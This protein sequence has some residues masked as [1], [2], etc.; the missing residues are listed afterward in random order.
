MAESQNSKQNVQAPE[1]GQTVIVNAIPGQDIVL[2]A[3]F[4]QAEVKMDG[5]NVV[6]EFANGGQVVLDFTDLGEAQAPN[7]V[8][9]DGTVL[10]MQEFLAALGEKEVEPAAGP[11]AG[12]V[13]S[14]GVGQ[15]REG[16][17]EVIDGTDKLDGLDPR[18]FASIVVE[19]LEADVTLENPLPTAGLVAG[20]V[21]E[22]GLGE[23][24]PYFGNYD[25]ASGDH[26]AQ[27]PFVEGSLSY[28]F[29]GD[30]PSITSPFSW[31]TTGLAAKG[32]TSEGNIL[33]YEVVDGGLTLNAYYFGYSNSGQKSGEKVLQEIVSTPEKI[34]VFALELTDLA[35]GD[36]RFEL[37]RPLDH[38]APGTE[39]D[40]LYNFTYTITDGSGDSVSGGL[41]MTIDDD[42]PVFGGINTAT[43]G[44]G[45]STTLEVEAG[46]KVSFDWFFDADELIFDPYRDFGFVVINGEAIKLADVAQVGTENATNWASFTYVAESDGLLTIGFGVMNAG[47]TGYD[48]HL[49]IDNLAVN[50]APVESFE[51]GN[52]SDNW[53]KLGDVAVVTSHDEGEGGPSEGAY[54]LRLT[55]GETPLSELE[56]F[57]DLEAG[58]L[59]AVSLG[60][61]GDIATVEDEKIDGNDE[62]DSWD[63]IF[64]G[65]IEDNVNWG[66]DGFRGATVFTVG[67][68]S[69]EPGT[70]VYWDQ[71]GNFL[72]ANMQPI[73]SEGFS[74]FIYDGPSPAA[75]LVVYANGQYV[76][77]LLDN[78][79][80]EPN[81][82]G[83]QINVLGSVIITGVD[84]DY[85]PIEVP[86]T[87]RVQDDVPTVSMNEKYT[88]VVSRVYEDALSTEAE[89]TD[90]SEGIREGGI[91]TDHDTVIGLAGSLSGLVAVKPGADGLGSV[92]FGL[93]TDTSKLPELYSD[94]VKLGYEVSDNTL[95]AKAGSTTIFTL[96]VN[97]DGSWSFDLDGQLD[98]VPGSEDTGVSLLTGYA[99]DE[100]KGVDGI[101]FSSLVGV[102]VTDADGDEAT[103]DGLD[104]GSFKIVVENDVPTVS[105]SEEFRP[106][107][108]KVY[109][110]ALSTKAE[111]T[112]SSEGI[113]E[114]GI[115]T[116]HD[117]VIGLA[118]SL[119]G[120]VA[121]KPGADGPGS[122]AFGM[123]DDT[124][125]LPE[126]YSDGVKLGYEVS[127]NTLTAKAGSTTIFT[128][129][130]NVDGSWSFDLDGQLDH[131]PGSGDT[132]VS[133]LTGYADD[134]PKGVDGIDFSSLVGVKVTDADGDE[135]TLDGLDKGSFKIVVEN[136]VPKV[137]V[138]TANDPANL[139]VLSNFDFASSA[140]Y[141]NSYGYYFKGEGDIPTNGVVV[142]NDVHDYGQEPSTIT[143]SG[144]TQD[145][146][147]FFIIP[148]GGNRNSFLSD[149]AKVVFDQVDGKWQAFLDNGSGGKGSPLAGNDFPVIF[150]EPS[151]NADGRDYMEDKPKTEGNQNWEDLPLS[152][153]DADFNDV[154]INAQW[155]QA[156]NGL[157]V[158]DESN[159]EINATLDLSGAFKVNYGADGPGGAL[160]YAFDLKD[161][162]SG[163]FDTATDLEVILRSNTNNTLVQGYIDNNGVKSVVFE[164]SVDG[165]GVVTLDQ[166]RAVVHDDARDPIEALDSAAR[167]NS[168]LISLVAT[169][170]DGDHDTHSASLDVGQM[171]RFEDDGPSAANAARTF[172]E[173]IPVHVSGFQAGFVSASPSNNVLASPT[174]LDADPLSDAYYWGG[175][176]TTGSGYKFVDKDDLRVFSDNLAG[177]P[178]ELG[179]FSHI[180]RPI[181]SG[182]SV[183]SV[184]LR[185][186]FMVNG[187]LVEHTIRLSHD[188]TTNIDNNPVASK[189]E[190]TINSASFSQQFSVAGQQFELK[191]LG[192]VKSDGSIATG[193]STF[194]NNVDS[195]GGPEEFPLMATISPVTAPVI[196]GKVNPDFGADGRGEVIWGDVKHPG[197]D[198]EDDYYV[199]ET[200]YGTFTGYADGSYKFVRSSFDVN[201]SVKLD[202]GYKVV[203]G[204]DDVARAKLSLTI[205]DSSEVTATNDTG[206]SAGATAVIGTDAVN[207]VEVV[208]SVLSTIPLNIQNIV[209]N[210][211]D[212][213]AG[214]LLGDNSRATVVSDTFSTDMPTTLNAHV[215]IIGYFKGFFSEDD[216]KVRLEVETDDSWQTV[217][218]KD[219]RGNSEITT[220]FQV[221]SAGTY[222]FVLDADDD[223]LLNDLYVTLSVDGNIFQITPEGR[224]NI[225]LSFD[226]VDWVLAGQVSGNVLL[227]DLQGVEGALV[228]EVGSSA[229]HFGGTVIEGTYGSLTIHPDGAYSYTPSYAPDDTD[230]IGGTLTESFTYKLVQPDGDSDTATLTFDV[231]PQLPVNAIEADASHVAQGYDQADD[232][233]F[234]TSGDDTLYGLAGND[235]INGGSGDD[236]I[237]GGD[238]NDHLIGAAGDDTLVGGDGDDLLTGGAGDDSMTGGNGVDVFKYVDG[239]LADVDAGDIIA[240]FNYQQ[241]HLDLSELLDGATTDNLGGY[242]HVDSFSDTQIKLSVDADGGGN[243]FT[244]LATIN[245]SNLDSDINQLNVLNEMITDGVLKIG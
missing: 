68:E 149:N 78:M 108:A 170:T 245:I 184:D 232:F 152:G 146:I 41:N 215:K 59:N 62:S 162:A 134:G 30:G 8:M 94:G 192:F 110:D 88:P 98:H 188:E 225:T 49:L 93:L 105:M 141:H 54:M 180:N 211:S 145:Q 36:Y 126:L 61:G 87:L 178:F 224:N 117:T 119:S 47:D 166:Q 96:T 171:V 51:S 240:D 190:I 65:T 189:D 86:L 206:G 6:F 15:F 91:T 217:E 5:G 198:G 244:T 35:N 216:V 34:V 177:S 95:T 222:R 202:F 148:N 23:G 236:S 127:D 199:T 154:N 32:V 131:V 99:D 197:A 4:D 121:V 179:K 156:S 58:A 120:L 204:D 52:L 226:D 72:G 242:L 20:V 155:T 25:S 7:V 213:N 174:D 169:A 63:K 238:G 122:V 85:D 187:E 21:D 10:D 203:D 219:F 101:D 19:A 200:P 67:E 234:G 158:V 125:K 137:E 118:G 201:D 138:V 27:L 143:V 45:V 175:D 176:S 71:H 9:P 209:A 182:S 81:D 193:I 167:I 212:A 84:G 33:S 24:A 1:T 172:V 135:A 109:E 230:Y 153:P 107:E 173:Q 106:I 128:L 55:S 207:F 147:G 89:P 112:D 38:S 208:P 12:A 29:G 243:D 210:P 92:A 186:K 194:E 223:T 16:A 142:W 144:Y 75:S 220:P 168:G 205:T 183:T 74:A 231:T 3:A 100:P 17:G 185:V 150:D 90:S 13:D 218:T 160:T 40:I 123:R 56:S 237:L 39:D 66:A 48:S 22:D 191:I 97:V 82:Q 124:S 116:D 133:L 114:G 181:G 221:P 115:T 80:L 70:T 161:G 235:Y 2:E 159:F 14:G 163:L 73:P 241:D 11:E 37:F 64:R 151:L 77:E 28:D 18:E 103:L 79:L 102:K 104:K 129:T 76:F 164:M 195:E 229:V 233:I 57:F 228:A 130:V 26:P 139:L 44:S 227:N 31:D 50:G 140:G 42:L 43:D 113:R 214:D 69:F 53:T 136:D 157:L 165:N 46:D 111:P 60:D 196:A 239:D 83:E 132:G